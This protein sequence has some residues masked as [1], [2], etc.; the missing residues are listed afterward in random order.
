MIVSNKL[1]RFVFV[2]LILIGGYL[3]IDYFLFD[4]IR[5]KPIK[6][7]GFVGYFYEKEDAQNQ[8]AIVLVGGGQWGAYWGSELAKRGYVALSLPYTREEGLPTLPEEIPLEYFENALKWLQGQPEVNSEKIILM[9]ASRNAELA[10]IIS[11]NIPELVDGV[12]AYAPSSVSWANRVLPYNSDDL[13]PSWTYRG[14]EIAY[15]SMEKII[16]NNSDT[17]NTLEY[18]KHGLEKE[19]DVKG[20]SIKA[21]QINGPILLLSG[22]DDQVWPSAYMADMLEQR[23]ID[24]GFTHKLENIQYEDAGH[25]IS[26]NPESQ[27]EARTGSMTIQNEQYIFKYGGT[28]LG[29]FKAKQDAKMRVLKFM[30]EL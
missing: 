4:G 28:S 7:H 9:G 15:I 3:I 26:S 1:V 5:P 8:K 10:L 11:A 13:K 24:H 23:T 12:I 16:P 17:I 22:K 6:V 14:S 21:E 25:L 29:D 30:E 19:D 27:D 18:W 20:A 2:L